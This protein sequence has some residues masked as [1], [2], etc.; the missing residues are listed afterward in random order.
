MMAGGRVEWIWRLCF[1]QSWKEAKRLLPWLPCYR[2]VERN[3]YPGEDGW[4]AWFR[5]CIWDVLS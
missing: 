4:H 1:E 5:H 3:G 2:V